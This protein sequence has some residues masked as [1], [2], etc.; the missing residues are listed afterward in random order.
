MLGA[1]AVYLLLFL[2]LQL[3]VDVRLV[4]LEPLLLFARLPRAMDLTVHNWSRPFNQAI[5]TKKARTQNLSGSGY[6]RI[7]SEK[8][9]CEWRF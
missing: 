7:T 1:D 4:A 3:L 5:K 2:L 8:W 6:G 9:G